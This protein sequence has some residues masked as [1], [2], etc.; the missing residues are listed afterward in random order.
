M[1]KNATVHK[2]SINTIK[3]YANNAKVHS[4]DQIQKIAN[5]IQEFGFLNPILLDSENMILCGHGRLQAAKSLGWDTVPCLYADGLTDA[6]KRAYILADNRLTELGG[7]D[8]EIL[9][10]ELRALIED[11]FDI[12]LTGFELDDE[13]DEVQD[14]TGNVDQYNP[15]QSLPDSRVMVCSI[16]TFGTDAEIFIEVALSQEDADRLLKRSQEIDP[17]V[18]AEKL[19]EAIRAV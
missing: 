2:V 10:Q 6:Q 3:P 18:I 4:P 14:D 19:R 15:T 7:W 12:D 5:S 13:T 8:D 16:S 9:D 1:L 17:A 11:G